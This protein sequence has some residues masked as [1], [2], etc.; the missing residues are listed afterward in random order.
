MPSLLTYKKM[1]GN[2]T[3]GQAHKVDSDMVMEATWNNSLEARTAYLYS[4]EYDDY[5]T[6]LDDLDSPNDKK[7]IPIE[8]KY[9]KHTS[10]TLAKDN[11][12]YHIMLRPS[13]GCNVP[14]YEDLFRKRCHSAF[15]IGLYI[16]I[17]D[18]KGRFNRWL[19]VAQADYNDAQFGTFDILRCDYVFD[20]VYKSKKIKMAGVLRSQ[21]S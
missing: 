4:Y 15:P 16:D 17:S 6:Q 19:V 14:Y 21:N 20:Y 5:K 7:K 3:E 10:Q 13:Q 8:I 12:S 2:L 11:V 9:I 18:S 1:L